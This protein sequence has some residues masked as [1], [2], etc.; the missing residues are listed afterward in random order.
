MAGE[1]DSFP[2]V[3]EG[4]KPAT[5]EFGDFP[6]VDAGSPAT[7]PQ[8]GS[9]ALEAGAR[10]G[11]QTS[12]F[13]AGAALG[14]KAGTAA[15][16]LLG[17]FAPAGPPVGGL[18]GG[19]GGFLAGQ[20]AS[21]GFGLRSPEEMPA[22]VR[23]GAYFGESL[24]GGLAAAGAPYGLAMTGTRFANNSMVGRYLNSI[25]ETAKSSPILFAAKEL[26][27]VVS[28]ATAAGM[29]EVVAPGNTV[30]RI[31][32]EVVGGL[33]NPVKLATSAASSAWEISRK[34]MTAI[35]P[36]AQQTAAAKLI[37]ELMVKTGEDPVATMRV[38]REMQK[39]PGAENLT[40][41]QLSGSPALGALQKR[42]GELNRTFGAE[43]AERADAAL[44]VMRW[45][46]A[47]LVKTG[48]PA[49]LAAAAQIRGVY[50]RT[51]LTGAK[52]AAEAQTL[53]AARRIA[54]D[55][56]DS[57]ERLSVQARD[58]LDKVIADTRVVEKDLWG[59]VDNTIPVDVTNL[60]NTFDDL[61]G[62]LL[63][64]LRNQKMPAVVSKFLNR[65]KSPK[66]APFAYDPE[67]LTVRQMDAGDAV[68]TNAKEMKQ[69]RSELLE[70]SRKSVIAGE[71]SQARI[72][73]QM[74]EAVL[75]DMDAAFASTKNS[76]YN[77]ARAFTKELND[78]FTR[79]FA[80]KVVAQGKYGD[81]VAPEILLRKALATGKEA[82]A[83]QMRE[84]EEA[85]RFLV[86][87]GLGDDI[88][89]KQMLDAQERLFRL[90]ASDAVDPLT[91]KASPERISKFIRD[92]GALMKRFPEV[93][94]DLLMAVKSEDRL[95]TV[96]NR[97]KNV[98]SLLVKQGDFATL[99]GATGSDPATRAAVARKITDRVLASPDQDAEL[100]KLINVAKGGG[101]GAAG[102]IAVKPEEAIDGLRASLFDSIINKSR[103]P[104][105]G[106]LNIEQ[107]RTHLFIPTSVGKKP[108]IAVMLD[109][110]VMK[111]EEISGIRR[112]FD[113]LSNIERAQKPGT[114]V[115]VK[116]GFSDVVMT[117]MARVAGSK[118]ASGF[119]QATGG[120]NSASLIV[121]GAAARTAEEIVTKIPMQ[122]VNKI[123]VEALNDP[124]KMN[125]L[126]TNVDSPAAA[127]KQARQ[128]HAWLV[129]S[130]LTGTSD[131]FNDYSNPQ[132]PPT[133]LTAPR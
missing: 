65:V 4:N 43:A 28:G 75:D 68:G 110:G 22:N 52:D 30:A 50:Y 11:L 5:G 72:Y 94:D 45:Q 47:T 13:M 41:A 58:A 40:S 24:G 73:N 96:T 103:N 126:L 123:I 10:G 85:T 54:K 122:S 67:T 98:E 118:A 61:A 49:A 18:L 130:G 59:K 48:D 91:G 113:L 8:Q 12:G 32:A 44:D 51:L 25:V 89:V 117:L 100:L 70:L 92:N 55:T 119:Q 66:E 108:L 26:P 19:V 53:N 116:T 120:A 95:K 60:E 39:L 105:D 20:H 3:T 46:I 35:S 71:D 93:K 42:M 133:M 77:E 81:R 29:A 80:G 106:V 88:A 128:I 2:A 86:T 23:P 125:I 6:A 131:I 14:V 16:P 74:A 111:Q 79:S 90:A 114:A 104:R 82:G 57:R 27:A 127:A 97:A 56:P 121:H 37:N 109:Q 83:M 64:E 107:V 115:E 7:L 62:D 129:Q 87:R 84:L 102:R 124:A 99:F 112:I 36:A 34:S 38:I 69:L 31:G 15:M 33:L 132:K 1:F 76:A 101:A 21:Q 9:A 17:P 78:V 63:P